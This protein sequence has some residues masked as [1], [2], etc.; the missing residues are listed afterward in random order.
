MVQSRQG[1]LSDSSQGKVYDV[2]GNKMYQPG[3]SYN[4]KLASWL[5]VPHIK[6]YWERAVAVIGIFQAPASQLKDRCEA[7]P[8]LDG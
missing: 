8:C 2:T 6:T 7:A 4:G 3:A 1:L 5:L